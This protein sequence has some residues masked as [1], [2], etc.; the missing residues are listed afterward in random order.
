MALHPSDSARAQPLAGMPG[1]RWNRN[2]GIYPT[3]LRRYLECPRRC[4]LEYIDRIRYERPWDRAMEVGVDVYL[5]KPVK[6]VEVLE[7]VKQLLRIR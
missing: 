6:F 7:T 3:S 1:P 2:K 4:R 5:R